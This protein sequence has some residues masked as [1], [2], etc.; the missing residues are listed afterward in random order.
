MSTYHCDGS[1]ADEV[2]QVLS[3]LPAANRV[4]VSVHDGRVLLRGV[5]NHPAERSAI[6]DLVADIDG[7]SAITDMITVQLPAQDDVPAAL[8]ISN[9]GQR[10][11]QARR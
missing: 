6:K 9:D 8:V 4:A 10:R 1:I 11:R 7:V 5:V 3:A 2:Y